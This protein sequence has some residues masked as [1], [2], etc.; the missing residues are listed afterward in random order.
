MLTPLDEGL[1]DRLA[2]LVMAFL[3]VLRVL[4]AVL[5]ERRR[6]AFSGVVV[7]AGAA[8]GSAARC[9]GARPSPICLASWD[10]CSE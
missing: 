2:F 6:A 7:G 10:R 9:A 3:A 5:A 4:V 8:A 1:R